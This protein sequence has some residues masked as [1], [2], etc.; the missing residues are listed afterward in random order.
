MNQED[1][2]AVCSR[3]FSRHT[4]LKKALLARYPN[5]RFNETGG[6]LS[7]QAL[8]AFLKGCNKAIIGL[9][10]VDEDLLKALPEL[11]VISKYGVGLDKIDLYAMT[12]HKRFLGWTPGVNKRSVSE[13]TLGLI[14]N[15]L[16]HITESNRQILEGNWKQFK[17]G[18][19]SGRCVGIIGCGHIGKDLVQLLKPFGCKILA[20]DIIEYHD[21]YEAHKVES[22]NK[23][24][25]LS[26]ADVV[27]LHTPL[28]DST[29]NIIGKKELKQMKPDSVLI[30]TARGGLVDEVALKE[31]LQ[32][33]EIL[34][35]AFDV[36]VVE[37]PQ[38]DDLLR[39]PNFIMTPHIGGS[40]EEAIF[41][42]GMASIDGL[43]DHQI[44][45]S[46]K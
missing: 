39:L 13:L 16:R 40:A 33:H 10:S 15:A 28:N 17:G 22:V 18:L 32:Q 38:D 19:L 4:E 1:Q 46:I 41:A 3:S 36:M 34:A 42:M 31:A 8:I 23:M 11:K 37:P 12:K 44:P 43:D 7:G 27:T 25:L 26:E 14:I 35:A 20:Y 9:E 5:V 6:Q 2:V 21:F 30:N 29:Q 24:K 45:E